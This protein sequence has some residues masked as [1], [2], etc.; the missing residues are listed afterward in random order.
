MIPS[1]FSVLT[2]RKE[3]T[4]EQIKVPGGETVFQKPLENDLMVVVL[5]RKQFL[6]TYAV[7][8][9]NY[10]SLDYKFRVPGGEVVEVPPGIAHFL[11]HKLFEEEE[12]SVFDRFA[13]WGG[14]VNAFTSY[15]QTSYLFSTIDNWRESLT[16]LVEFVNRPHLT[17][18][19]V[20]KEKG[21][22]EQELQM[23][24]DHPDHRIHSA[25][26]QNLYHEHPV[27]LDIGG[28][29]ESV[30]QITVDELFRC[31]HTF[32]QPSNMVLVVVGDV[33][34]KETYELVQKSYPQLPGEGGPVE[35]LDP[36]E[37]QSVVRPWSE[38]ELP[39]SRPRYMLGFKH[40]PIWKGEE[41][42]RM[43]IAM[44]LGFKLI[45]GR[46]SKAYAE[47]YEERLIDDSF[48]ASFGAHSRYAMSVF[49]SETDN[50]EALHAKLTDIINGLKGGRVEAGEVE[51]LKKQYVGLYLGSF[52]SFE[53]TANRLVSQY[54]D[55][56][57]YYRYLELLE[58]VTAENVQS[59]LE[60][61]LD[62]E[63]SSVAI[64]RPVHSHG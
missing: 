19:N 33:D 32:Y 50:P 27:R 64:L 35:R 49:S 25:L 17:E 21:I 28:T 9:V 22:I 14:S 7:L 20:E 58:Q 5:P 59:A 37:P 52:D 61:L 56:T 48:Y 8:S 24:A 57:P 29:V 54:F 41:L 45:S 39:I 15:N 51:R 13:A 6:R 53:Y 3:Q 1:T 30:R 42:V 23:Y 26:L 18:E 4:M 10:G 44:S 16:Y 12:G 2:H 40:D 62:W 60:D 63:R 36:Q 31:Y 11:E 38:E 34:P 43:Q 55:G 46:S 47:L